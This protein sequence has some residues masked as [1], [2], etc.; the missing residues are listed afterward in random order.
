MEKKTGYDVKF[1]VGGFS[2][3]SGDQIISIGYDKFLNAFQKTDS[4]T[5]ALIAD[6]LRAYITYVG[7]KNG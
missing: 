1:G 2:I 7:V 6:Y 4:E 5:K 3:F